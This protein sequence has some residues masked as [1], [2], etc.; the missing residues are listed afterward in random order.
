MKIPSYTAYRVM[1]SK[2]GRNSL[3]RCSLPKAL[4][5]AGASMAGPMMS[6][7]RCKIE[8]IKVPGTAD[9]KHVRAES[10]TAAVG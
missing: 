1:G 6:R 4:A 3:T 8:K 9:F 10:A 5:G 7:E 2:S